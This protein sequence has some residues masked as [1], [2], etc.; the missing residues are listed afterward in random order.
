MKIG[1]FDSGFGGL[2]VLKEFLKLLPQYD[3]IYLGDNARTPYGT[4][5]FETVYKYTLQAVKKLFELDCQLIILACNTA[6][7][8]A[9]RSIQQKDLPKLAPQRRVLGVI[10]PSV[11]ALNK[12]TKTANIGILATP[13]TVK[14]ESYVME[15]KKLFPKM[16]VFQQAAPMWVPLVENNEH[17][18]DGADYFVEKYIDELMAQS[19]KIDTVILGCTHYPLLINKIKKF[20]PPNVNL[21]SQGGIVA[22]SLKDY[23]KRHPEIETKL[24]KNYKREFYTT[25]LPE[26]FET[27][28]KIFLSN[29]IMPRTERICLDE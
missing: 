20:L 10:R 6:S 21:L 28:A 23:L 26:N 29:D 5:T 11:E 16:N 27:K 2:T 14:S 7:S 9:L 3:Y 17:N 22:E 24:S 4:R 25:E 12:Y 15:I 13:A 1:V 18:S 8:K 19:S